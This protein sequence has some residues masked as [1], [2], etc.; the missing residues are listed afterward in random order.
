ML[1]PSVK[2][3]FPGQTDVYKKNT[4]YQLSTKIVIRRYLQ[5]YLNRDLKKTKPTKKQKE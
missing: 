1:N 3:V 4:Y 5:I 2:Q